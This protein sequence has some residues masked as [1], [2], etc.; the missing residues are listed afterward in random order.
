MTERPFG[1]Q[2]RST[3]ISLLAGITAANAFSL[4]STYVQAKNHGTLETLAVLALGIFAILAAISHT[5]LASIESVQTPSI[6]RT[7]TLDVF[8]QACVNVSLILAAA[9]IVAPDDRRWLGLCTWSFAALQVFIMCKAAPL[10][11]TAHRWRSGFLA[12]VRFVALADYIY[13]A[14]FAFSYNKRGLEFG[15][16][17]AIA[18]AALFLLGLF[19]KMGKAE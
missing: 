13:L 1:Q 16:A 18:C 15:S 9:W 4:V 11:D 17:I 7:L 12:A 8:G 19:R 2:V 5:I 3:L 10:I 14:S 6:P